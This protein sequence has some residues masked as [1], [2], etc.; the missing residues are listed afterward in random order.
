MHLSAEH[1]RD[2][3]GCRPGRIARGPRDGTG[4]GGRRAGARVLRER[5]EGLR[6]RPESERPRRLGP[7]DVDADTAER[8]LVPLI[9][10]G[11]RYGRSRVEVDV[12]SNGDSVEFLVNDDG[13][14]IDL[15]DRERIFEPGSAVTQGLP[16]D[17]R[18]PA[19]GWPWPGAWPGRSG[20]TSRRSGTATGRSSGRGYRS[21][22]AV[23]PP[24]SGKRRCARASSGRA[25]GRRRGRAA[26]CRPGSGRAACPSRC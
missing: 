2:A 24:A 4:C 1:S 15:A 9:E 19:S 17:T 21:R 7:V 20:G 26:R 16:E 10:N 6:H 18:A 12:Q 22:A 8:I 25:A 11:C 14:G 23:E 3:D 5:R 13:P